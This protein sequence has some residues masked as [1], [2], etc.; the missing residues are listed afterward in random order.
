MRTHFSYELQYDASSPKTQ[1]RPS[2]VMA[3]LE[4]SMATTLKL[5]DPG[6]T[7]TVSNS[8]KGN[9]N[10]FLEIVAKASDQQIGAVVK[11]FCADNNVTVS[12]LE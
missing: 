11:T 4:S 9:S 2:E 10:K 6:A 12:L 8:R 7:V 3:S 1:G 5:I